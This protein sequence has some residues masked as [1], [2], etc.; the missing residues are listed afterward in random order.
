MVHRKFP[1]PFS[2]EKA[3]LYWMRPLFYKLNVTFGMVA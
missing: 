3:H 1:L 2:K